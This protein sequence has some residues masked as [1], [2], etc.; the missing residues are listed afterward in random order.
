MSDIKINILTRTSKRPNWFEYNKQSIL[1]QTY[2]NI[3]HI[4]SYDNDETYEYLKDYDA[5][6]VKIDRQKLIDADK[7]KDPKTGKY[8]PH[9]LYFNEMMKHVEDG[10]VII[11][12]DDD[13]FKSADVLQKIVNNITEGVD[14]LIWQMSFP[15]ANFRVLPPPGHMYHKKPP[16]LG[17]IGSPCIGFKT[18]SKNTSVQW[19]GWKCG[20]F[21]FIKK[22]YSNSENI[23]YITDVLVTVGQI[24]SGNQT[25]LK[26]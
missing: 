20:D 24:G 25:D 3:K 4:V 7:S 22:I 9:N 16:M 10:W 26:K 21:R 8:S 6:L 13:R 2:K 1:Q 12:D 11:L 18:T 5:T 17:F 19:D 15:V 14:M 23:K